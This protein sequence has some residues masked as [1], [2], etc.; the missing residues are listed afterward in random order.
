MAKKETASECRRRRA[1]ELIED[2]EPIA[3]IARFLGVSKKVVYHWYS[4]LM[5]DTFDL[6]QV[7]ARSRSHF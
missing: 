2:G 5:E 1:V 6:N 3:L 4:M 7:T